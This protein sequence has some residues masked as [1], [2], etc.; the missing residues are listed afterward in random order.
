MLDSCCEEN[1]IEQ[2][3]MSCYTPFRPYKTKFDGARIYVT[4]TIRTAAVIATGCFLAVALG[5]GIVKLTNATGHRMVTVGA[6]SV[7][8]KLFALPALLAVK[9]LLFI[10]FICFV[11]QG[12][13]AHWGWGVGILIFPVVALAFLFVH[14]R[15]AK[16][17]AIVWGCG[18]TLLLIALA[19]VTI[20]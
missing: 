5:F 14:P 3:E 17:P 4:Q 19:W 16:F 10:G 18:V 1:R 9:G 13:R 2:R 15:Q 20:L 7:D 11:I 12:F 6:T 8:I